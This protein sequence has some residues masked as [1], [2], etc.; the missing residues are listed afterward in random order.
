MSAH[1]PGPWRA[2]GRRVV[3]WSDGGVGIGIA[4]CSFAIPEVTDECLANARLI[5]AAPDLLD[6]LRTL[7]P[8]ISDRPEAASA[9]PD[10][11]LA[12]GLAAIA[13]AEGRAP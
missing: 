9:F 4:D 11:D 3:K 5:A 2:T 1:T 12:P 13:K 10:E 7:L 8:Q 6:A